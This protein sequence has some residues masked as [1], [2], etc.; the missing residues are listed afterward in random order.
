MIDM[1]EPCAGVGTTGEALE[2][3]NTYPD[4][5]CVSTA[6]DEMIPCVRGV[7]A[8]VVP[9]EVGTDRVKL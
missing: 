7:R 6:V 8:S 9:V 4:Y 5:Y 1:C 2:S 3:P